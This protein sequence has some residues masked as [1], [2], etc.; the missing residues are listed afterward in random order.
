MANRAMSANELAEYAVVVGWR[1]LS[2]LTRGGDI[3]A[4]LEEEVTAMVKHAVWRARVK[5][6]DAST[7]QVDDSTG[8]P[9]SETIGTLS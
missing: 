4:P 7:L 8:A 3:T 2:A 5:G 9:S 6:L 1:T